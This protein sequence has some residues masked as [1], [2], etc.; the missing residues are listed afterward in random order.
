MTKLE[1]L[2]LGHN[3]IL[4]FPTE[5]YQL[6]NLEFLDLSQNPINVMDFEMAKLKKLKYLNI[7]TES[8]VRIFHF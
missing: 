3:E 8:K 2:D 1:K 4:N 6:K 5:I 7:S